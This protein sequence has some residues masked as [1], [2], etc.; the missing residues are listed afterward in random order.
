M[1]RIN[2]YSQPDEYGTYGSPDAGPELLGWFDYDKAEKIHED[3]EWDGRNHI[4]VA[5]GSQW[6]HEMLLRTAQGR[7]VLETYSNRQGVMN[8][9]RFVSD[10]EAR[11]WLL[12]NNDDANAAKYFGPVEE[13]RGPGRPKIG[14]EVLVRL[15]DLLDDV[16]AYAKE[17]GQSRA[18]VIRIAVGDFLTASRPYAVTFRDVS[19]GVRET[20][21][22]HAT[23][24]AAVEAFRAFQ[25]ADRESQQY[26]GLPSKQPRVE[27]DGRPVD[28][29]AMSD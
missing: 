9:C 1:T 26:R 8:T 21:T 29:E 13:E 11:E 20:D 24:G 5:T 27:H 15:G 18:E 28:V 7:W 23:L 16:D 3:T 6:D 25:E 14:G 4:S 19:T 10:T 2:V 12:R 22:R 17:N